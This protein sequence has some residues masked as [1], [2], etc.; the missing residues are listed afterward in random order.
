M[1]PK[2]KIERRLGEVLNLKADRSAGPKS[3]I[4]RRPTKPGQHGNKR[5]RKAPSDFGKQLRETSKFKLTYGINDLTLRRLFAAASKSKGDVGA[6]LM[7]LFESRLQNVVYRSGLTPSRLASRAA[8][9][10]GH[11]KVNG[12]RTVSPGYLVKKGDV[13]SVR[14]ES[15]SKGQFKNLAEDVKR[16]EVPSWI[17]V[18]GA[19]MEAK[20]LAAPENI[21]HRFEINLLV[22]SFSK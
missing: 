13:V 6:K 12:R 11:I 15:R 16:I 18:D 8:I 14:E 21:E 2:G 5:S 3:P 17:S 20:I 4:N 22:E 9:I 1:G 10:N 19:K 7:Q